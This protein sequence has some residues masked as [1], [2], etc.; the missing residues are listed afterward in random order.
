MSLKFIR[1]TKSPDHIEELSKRIRNAPDVVVGFPFSL[2]SNQAARE[3]NGASVVDVAIWNNFGTKTIPERRFMEASKKQITKATESDRRKYVKAIM[4]G[5]MDPEQA[6]EILGVK[7]V[8]V[9][10]RVINDWSDPPN[11]PLTI[12]GGWI[13]L[14]NGKKCYIK[15]KKVNNPLVDTGLMRNMVTWE[16]RKKD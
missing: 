2:R 4:D 7:S 8:M 14:P 15:G 3:P 11:S 12:N 13:T 1:K 16:L 10:R 6:L 9:I 5:K